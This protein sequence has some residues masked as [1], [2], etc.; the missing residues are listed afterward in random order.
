M[1]LLGYSL[2]HKL[3]EI[4]GLEQVK[5]LIQLAIYPIT[6]PF[7]LLCIDIY[8]MPTVLAKAVE[9]LGVTVHRIRSLPEG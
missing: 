7:H 8:V 6:E 3:M 2:V 5:S 4:L 1:I 9:L